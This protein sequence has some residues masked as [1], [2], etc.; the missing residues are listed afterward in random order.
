MDVSETVVERTPVDHGDPARLTVEVE[1]RQLREEL[2]CARAKALTYATTEAQLRQKL[3]VDEGG[4]IKE[5]ARLIEVQH[6]KVEKLLANDRVLRERLQI[7]EGARDELERELKSVCQMQL[8]DLI[9]LR[10]L[11]GRQQSTIEHQ[12]IL[13]ARHQS[14]L[15]SIV[16]HLRE[17]EK[18]VAEN[19][20]SAL[21]TL[22]Q[23]RYNRLRELTA[24]HEKLGLEHAQVVDERDAL[25]QT[26]LL[27]QT[28][29]AGLEEQAKA[30]SAQIEELRSR[31]RQELENA[32]KSGE[33]NAERRVAQVEAEKREAVEQSAGA[34]SSLL[35]Q[36]HEVTKTLAEVRLTLKHKEEML[37]ETKQ[38]AAALRSEIAAL[39]LE[40]ER[41]KI[42]TLEQQ[43]QLDSERQALADMRTALKEREEKLW[44]EGFS[45]DISSL[46][47][48]FLDVLE[49]ER[50]NQQLEA[51]LATLQDHQQLHNRLVSYTP[52]CSAQTGRRR[53]RVSGAHA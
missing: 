6:L 47:Y 11:C 12:R 10:E 39:K 44:Q 49:L 33:L 46:G 40:S 35:E 51:Q 28:K 30:L 48:S 41:S 2:L 4:T 15:E 3:G 27:L 36:H 29:N 24:L 52:S 17:V 8:N 18:C 50:R 53:K 16:S 25:R 13:I 43:V 45:Q 22:D 21:K 38:Q 7:S 19:G 37:G 31:H 42:S 32:C 26:N 34:L 1:I 20:P 9:G 14:D 5:Q 23:E